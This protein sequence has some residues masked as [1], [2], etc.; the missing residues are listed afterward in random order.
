MKCLTQNVEYMTEV[1][2]QEIRFSA[3]LPPDHELTDHKALLLEQVLVEAVEKTL[4]NLRQQEPHRIILISQVK[5]DD[6]S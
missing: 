5:Q 6:K 1:H 3:L 4:C 2:D